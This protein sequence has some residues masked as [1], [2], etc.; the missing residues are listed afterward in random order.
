MTAGCRLLLD[1][2]VRGLIGSREAV[3]GNKCVVV[4][5]TLLR[6]E[7]R[8]KLIVEYLPGMWNPHLISSLPWISLLE[9]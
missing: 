9:G 4:H 1:D 6:G 7:L 3:P 8:L 2:L 5:R